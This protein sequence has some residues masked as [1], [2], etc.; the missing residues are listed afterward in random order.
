[1][2]IFAI[3]DEQAMLD[4]LHEAIAAAEPGAEIHDFKRAKAAIAT[5]EDGCVPDVIFTDIELPGTN[6]LAFAKS[7]KAAVPD[8]KIVF[9]TAYPSYAVDAFRLHADGF[10]VKPVE[11]SRVREELDALFPERVRPSKLRVRCFGYFD[12]FY[13]DEPLAM[14]RTRSKELLAFLVDRN[15]GTCTSAEIAHALWE[16][17]EV[18]DPAAYL[19]MLAIDLRGALA[20]VGM[21]DV[22]IRG[23]N[24]WAVR[25]KMLD[26]DYYRMLAGDADA[27]EAY[28][29]EYMKQYS[30][31]EETAGKLHFMRKGLLP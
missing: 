24:Q 2:R 4:E 12:V 13:G 18:K 7:V 17:G 10:V 26:C 28:Q 9:V 23:R 29:G 20:S 21:E 6:G 15:G 22:L 5:I 8:A 27:I 31:A 30:W 16:S 25:T 3:D 19:R 1:M 14:S 11:V